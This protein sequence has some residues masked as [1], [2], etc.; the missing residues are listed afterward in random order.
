MRWRGGGGE[1]EYVKKL[2]R[3]GRVYK[4]NISMRKVR[5]CF[6]ISGKAAA[7]LPHLESDGQVF[8]HVGVFESCQEGVEGDQAEEDLLR[9][10]R[11]PLVE[12][13]GKLD[14]FLRHLGLQF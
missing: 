7:H 4:W 2:E 13:V 10:A 5:E 1:G 14:R 11:V 6:D 9:P 8:V 12:A 3:D